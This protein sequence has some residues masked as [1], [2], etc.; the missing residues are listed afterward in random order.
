MPR[1]TVLLPVRDQAPLLRRAMQS[2]LQQQW[3]DLQLLVLDDGSQ[4][5]SG[6]IAAAVRD[7][8]VVVHRSERKVGLPTI[9][10][11]GLAISDSEFVARMDADDWSHPG[12]LS[13]QI[14]FLDSQPGVAACGTAVTVATPDGR[15]HLRRYPTGHEA[16]RSRLLFENALAHPAIVLRRSALESLGL[17]Y[18]PGYPNSQDYDLWERLSRVARLAN[19][20]RSYLVYRVQPKLSGHSG[21]QQGLADQVRWRQLEALAVEPSESQWQLQRALCVWDAAVVAPRAAELENWLQQLIDANRAADIY[22]QAAFREE[23][24]MRFRRL[25]RLISRHGADG[26][27]CWHGASTLR[28]GT[29]RLGDYLRMPLWYRDRMKATLSKG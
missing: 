21:R 27:S 26:W 18:H 19:L 4:D 9:L 12:R 1:V 24:L 11:Q 14:G 28:G 22:P 2:I 10:N 5:G 29:Y 7:P 8:R 15:R 6:D 3:H 16:I 25:C 23:V 20:G 13:A 17:T